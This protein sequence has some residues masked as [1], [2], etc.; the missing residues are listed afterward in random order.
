MSNVKRGQRRDGALRR[1][2]FLHLGL[3]GAGA[4]A[5]S[6]GGL[7]GTGIEVE[8][9]AVPAVRRGGTLVIGTAQSVQTLDPHQS[10]LRN[11]RNAWIGLF[12]FLTLY[13]EQGF[14]KPSLA[15]S[16]QVGRDGLSW[17][18]KLRRG[19]KFHNGRELTADDVKFSIERVLQ[20]K[21]STVYP[22]VK[23]IERILV[24]DR[25]TATIVL[26]QPYSIL[27][28][29][30]CPL[31]IIA[32]ENADQIA[33]KPIGTGPFRLKEYNVG[34]NCDLERFPDYWE[35]GPG[36]AALPYLDAVGIR[37]LTDTNA[38]FTALTTGTVQAFWQMPDQIQVQA[39]AV[40]QIQ[41]LPARFKTTHD[42]YFFQADAP[43]F[44]QKTV[45]EAL[46]LA[47]DK[48]AIGQ[49]GYYGHADPR[50]NNNIV[51][52]GSWAERA[53]IPDI[54][55]DPARAKQLFAAAGVTRL[56]FLGYTETPQFKP[57]SEVME[58]NLNE[59][60][61]GL[62]LV[63]TDLTTWLS[64]IKLGNQSAA[65][66]DGQ[67]GNAFTPNISVTPPDPGLSVATWGC[68]AHFGSHFCDQDL[69][70]AAADGAKYLEIVKRKAA[71]D[72]YQEIWRNDVP[73]FIT[74]FRPFTHA[75]LRKIHGLYDDDGAL[76]FRYAWMD[77]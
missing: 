1:R 5:A 34:Q 73:A 24:P 63:F 71:Y 3:A 57:I 50:L 42:E 14:P 44:Q 25:Y 75:S 17:T 53:D 31:A 18:F 55:R 35:K 22:G 4:A 45:R 27:A 40:P 46:L 38:L 47:L 9:A 37:T 61:I 36:N 72:R 59:I 19:V 67:D 11:N 77:A 16:W 23:A 6:L 76:N 60:G 33:T 56:K 64:R 28:S 68:H 10:G 7:A 65:W 48:V 26:N 58:R 66:D 21:P 54:K 20:K 12:S 39:T 32:R 70:N 13:N 30:L 74:C 8:G 69:A 15:E 62:D 49:A 41:L 52:P 51:P 2:E 29:G 43:P